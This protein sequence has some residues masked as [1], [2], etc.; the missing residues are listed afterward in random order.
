VSGLY[1][2]VCP[3]LIIIVHSVLAI[4]PLG[5]TENSLLGGAENSFWLEKE[6]E[7]KSLYVLF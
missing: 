6:R 5:V 7:R 4:G 1:Y 3:A 2:F